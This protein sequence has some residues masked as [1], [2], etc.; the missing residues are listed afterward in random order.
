MSRSEA[1]DVTEDNDPTASASNRA[2]VVNEPI[3]FDSILPQIGEFGI[4]QKV[5]YLL[6]CIPTMPA[7]FLA[8]NQVRFKD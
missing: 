5:F 7:A 4:Y 8:F 2:S 6:M 3:D 1:D